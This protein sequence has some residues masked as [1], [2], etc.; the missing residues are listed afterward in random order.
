MHALPAN[1]NKLSVRGLEIAV[2]PMK[3]ILCSALLSGVAFSAHAVP[4]PFEFVGSSLGAS[5]TF[6]LGSYSSNAGSAWL[7][8]GESQSF[9]FGAVDVLGFGWGT[10]T[11]TVEFV[12]PAELDVG[13]SGPY[14][15]I[16]V[17]IVNDGNWSGGSTDFAYTYNG[18]S[19]T[20]RLTLSPI[21]DTCFLCY[22][23]FEFVGKITNLG[24][25]AAPVP[26]PAPTTLSLLGLGLLG[27]GAALRRH[28]RC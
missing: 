19:G 10:L 21:D 20:A 24:S 2:T 23:T 22:P 8:D 9:V 13:V 6:A 1:S 5:G 16:A 18:Y 15:V 3:K 28:R 7:D 27:T 4:I 25:S 12:N 17:G 11:L 26:V 14:S